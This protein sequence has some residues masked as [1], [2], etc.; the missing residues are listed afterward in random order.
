MSKEGG[1]GEG[2]GR[3]GGGEGGKGGDRPGTKTPNSPL[4]MK[5]GR[6]KYKKDEKSWL[7]EAGE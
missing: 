6:P 1:G 2:E 3:G 7:M 4:K 5:P